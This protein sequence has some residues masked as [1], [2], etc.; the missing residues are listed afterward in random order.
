MRTIDTIKRYFNEQV[1]D[2]NPDKHELAIRQSDFE[3]IDV[4][5]TED[6]AYQEGWDNAISK[7]KPSPEERTDI[8]EGVKGLLNVRE[9][10]MDKENIRILGVCIDALEK[11]IE[12]TK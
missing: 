1:L 10:C 9:K 6:I 7:I 8:K 2:G 3:V 11:L 4:S 12:E 5:L